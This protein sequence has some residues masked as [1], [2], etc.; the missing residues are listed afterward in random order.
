MKITQIGSCMVFG[1]KTAA[2]EPYT[3]IKAEQNI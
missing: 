1:S 3:K 2:N